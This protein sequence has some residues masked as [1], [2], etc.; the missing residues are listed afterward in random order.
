MI[1][2]EYAVAYALLLWC[3]LLLVVV[4]PQPQHLPVNSVGNFDIG[5]I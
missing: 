3:W 2:L 5:D 4:F 1:P